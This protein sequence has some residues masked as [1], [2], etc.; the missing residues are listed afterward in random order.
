MIPSIQP[1]AGFG[2]EYL[3]SY[4]ACLQPYTLQ[5]L[6]MQPENT[7]HGI[8]EFKTSEP[9]FFQL[10]FVHHRLGAVECHSC[11]C[12]ISQRHCLVDGL[13][14][15]PLWNE[16]ENPRSKRQGQEGGYHSNQGCFFWG[17]GG[18]GSLFYQS[19]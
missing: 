11:N 12:C 4:I 18:R 1:V 5:K 10:P 9:S 7:F 3:V 2:E 14:D 8:S 15:P 17:S 16:T 13:W 19:H 6:N